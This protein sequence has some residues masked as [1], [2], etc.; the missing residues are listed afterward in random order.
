MREDVFCGLACLF[1]IHRAHI[2]KDTKLG[3]SNFFRKTYLSHGYNFSYRLFAKK[4]NNIMHTFT[5]TKI[6]KYIVM[7]YLFKK[8]MQLYYC[9]IF[10]YT[11][12]QYF[13][14]TVSLCIE[15]VDIF[16]HAHWNSQFGQ[17]ILTLVAETKR[18]KELRDKV[19]LSDERIWRE[20]T[21]RLIGKFSAPS[22]TIFLLTRR[23]VFFFISLIC[24]IKLKI[25]PA[26]D[27]RTAFSICTAADFRMRARIFRM[28]NRTCCAFSNERWSMVYIHIYLYCF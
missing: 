14:T 20:L 12:I 18:G 22:R 23:R 9:M 17:I 5:V 11:H 15:N 25:H 10:I 6:L 1:Y 16:G 24:K 27:G 28:E 13:C 26:I 19:S 8:N 2:D 7:F 4:V 3:L 21:F